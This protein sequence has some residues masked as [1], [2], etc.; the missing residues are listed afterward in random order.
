MYSGPD[1]HSLRNSNSIALV[2]NRRN[3]LIGRRNKIKNND[4]L[5]T[6]D[7]YGQ[8]SNSSSSYGGKSATIA[9]TALED[10]E[11]TAYGSKFTV[12]TVAPTT[13]TMSTR[14]TLQTTAST[15]NT[16]SLTVENVSGTDILTLSTTSAVTTS[17]TVTL[18]TSLGSS[19]PTL[20]LR[21]NSFGSLGTGSIQLVSDSN[22]QLILDGTGGGGTILQSGAGLLRLNGD[23]NKRIDLEANLNTDVFITAGTA[24]GN[25]GY[26]N[27][28]SPLKIRATTGTPTNYENGY[29]EDMLATPVSWLKI[30][31]GSSDYYLPLFQ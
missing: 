26:V 25:T 16:D 18:Q 2:A 5:H 13:T 12:E 1:N 15:I 20:N 19:G 10:F 21:K 11:T 28:D 3:G 6:I 24:S 7:F 14:L 30:R 27:I 8:T 31:I 23:Y 29:F 22:S 4:I 17:D 9:V